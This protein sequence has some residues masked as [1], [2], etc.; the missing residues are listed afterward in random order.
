[1]PRVR[2]HENLMVGG[3]LLAGVCCGTACAPQDGRSELMRPERLS[4]VPAADRSVVAPIDRVRMPGHVREAAV[5]KRISAGAEAVGGNSNSLPPLPGATRAN[6]VQAAP[7]EG[8]ATD[9]H[10]LAETLASQGAGFDVPLLVLGATAAGLL[11]AAS[12]PL[13][14]WRVR[15]GS[16]KQKAAQRLPLPS[17]P[18]RNGAVMKQMPLSSPSVTRAPLWPSVV[19]NEVD[20]GWQGNDAWSCTLLSTGKPAYAPYHD[21]LEG[22]APDAANAMSETVQQVLVASTGASLSSSREMETPQASVSAAICPAGCPC[23]A[24]QADLSHASAQSL[25]GALLHLRQ[26]H[27]HYRGQVGTQ[28][29]TPARVAWS[30]MLAMEAEVLHGPAKHTR[31]QEAEASLVD[32]DL[33]RC[34]DAALVVARTQLIRQLSALESHSKAL[35]RLKD[36]AAKLASRTPGQLDVDMEHSKLNETIRQRAAG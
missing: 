7:A 9:R 34:P 12:S 30:T 18:I 8:Y 27:A 25:T 17:P 15:S 14:W 33:Q 35:Q 21:G 22:S 5:S 24:M 2:G 1:M 10:V 32:V 3:T 29:C 11:G 16:A 13:W 36:A 26:M 19:V 6:H 23:H 4:M 20:V 31:Y 28:A